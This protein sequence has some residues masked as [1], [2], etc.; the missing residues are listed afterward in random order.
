MFCAS[1][2]YILFF[3]I[4]RTEC[5]VIREFLAGFWNISACESHSSLKP[6]AIDPKSALCPFSATITPYSPHSY[7]TECITSVEWVTKHSFFFLGSKS[8]NAAYIHAEASSN[9]SIDHVTLTGCPMWGFCPDLPVMLDIHTGIAL[10]CLCASGF[11]VTTGAASSPSSADSWSIGFREPRLI[12]ARM[13][14]DLSDLGRAYW[15]R[16]KEQD[17]I[18]IQNRAFFTLYILTPSHTVILFSLF[19]S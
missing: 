13:Q 14:S 17:E 5:Q 6:V 9:R 11:R 1:S 3:W 18:S 4:R 12:S 15:D 16:Q 8:A 10:G 7:Q 2:C 19:F